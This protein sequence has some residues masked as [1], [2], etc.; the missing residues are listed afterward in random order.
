MKKL[1]P[2]LLM[3][4]TVSMIAQ[5]SPVGTWKTIDDESGE[6]KSYLEIYE[7]SGKLYGKIVKI[8]TGEPDAICEECKGKLKNKPV[9]NMVIMEKLEKKS[10]YWGGGT[11]LDPENGNVYKCKIW[12][13]ESNQDQL[14][15]RGIH[16]T[17]IYRT[18]TW[19]RVKNS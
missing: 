12:L 10:T 1:L 19:Y 3:F 13:D 7:Q 6:E 9:L 17:G 5:S 14:K 15:V 11:I 16:W 4:G 8:L 18:Q 2:F